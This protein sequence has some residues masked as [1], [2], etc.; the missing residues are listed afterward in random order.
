MT[1]PRIELG[2]SRCKRDGLP[3][4][5]GVF[6]INANGLPWISHV[7]EARPKAV[8]IFDAKLAYGV[9]KNLVLSIL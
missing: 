1:P 3:L 8:S 9:I 6:M 7:S 5:Y 2:H 4:A